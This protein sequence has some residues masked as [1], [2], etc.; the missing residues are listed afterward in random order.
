MTLTRYLLLTVAIFAGT[1]AAVS[2]IT[3]L[4]TDAG[5]AGAISAAA[6]IAAE[7]IA[8][9][10]R[11][12]DERARRTRAEVWERRDGEVGVFYYDGNCYAQPVLDHDY[13]A[14]WPH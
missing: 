7:G 9:C 8:Y 2:W 13:R 3:G 11:R 5:V 14:V 12:N 4:L 1:Y 6:V 10:Q